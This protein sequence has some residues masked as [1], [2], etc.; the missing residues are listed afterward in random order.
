MISII[1]PTYNSSKFIKHTYQ[2]ILVQTINDW[3][4]LVT[5]DCS[6]DNTWHILWD[7]AKND[8]RLKIMKNEVNSGAA[9][10]RNKCLSRA[11]GEFLAF[12]DAD[13]TWVPEKIEKQVNY[14]ERNN[15][16]FS[17]TAYELINENGKSLKKY[18]DINNTGEFSYDDMLR[19]K[20]TLGCSTVML[21][22]NT[23]SD[24]TM[25]HIRTGQDYAFWLKLLKNG[26]KA[27][28]LNEP[29]TKYRIVSNSISRNKFRKAMRQWQ[30]YRNLE[31][32]SL[33]E[34]LECFF[35][36]AIRAVFR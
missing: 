12:I 33:I 5:D 14:M 36:Y 25:P 32:L 26:E 6:T 21:R 17:F 16:N 34:T 29:L 35:Y 28:L 9:V 20:A 30:I 4:W 10:T 27:Y 22:G 1:T 19:K 7:L 18:I 8:P 15:I 13:D 23:F 11:T 31:K 2:S 24:L 3:E